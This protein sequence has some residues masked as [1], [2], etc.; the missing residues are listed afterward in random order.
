MKING[1]EASIM[2][3]YKNRTIEQRSKQATT[4][5][6]SGHHGYWTVHNYIH[7]KNS[8]STF[9]MIHSHLI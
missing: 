3:C 4:L 8:L 6:H 5:I 1:G 9:T 2:T 7:V